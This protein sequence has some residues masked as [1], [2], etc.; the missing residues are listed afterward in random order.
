[1]PQFLALSCAGGRTLANGVNVSMIVRMSGTYGNNAATWLGKEFGWDVACV[2][3]GHCS[4][5]VTEVYAEVDRDKAVA[6]ME[7]VG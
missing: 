6:I 7:Q 4:P 2:I 1:M 3:L 5:T